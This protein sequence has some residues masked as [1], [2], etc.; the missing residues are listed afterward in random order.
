MSKWFVCGAFHDMMLSMSN[1]HDVASVISFILERRG[2]GILYPQQRSRVSHVWAL[3]MAVWQ[4]EEQA[5][6][7]LTQPHALLEGRRPAEV[8]LTDEGVTLVKDILGRLTHGSA[9]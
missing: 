8:A 2:G 1:E 9:V 6:T 7:F 5:Y 3:S 4:H